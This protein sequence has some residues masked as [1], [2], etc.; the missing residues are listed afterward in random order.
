MSEYFAEYI[1][2]DIRD[3]AARDGTTGP[4]LRSEM[5]SLALYNG[6]VADWL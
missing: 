6:G 1:H 4:L 2:K 3:L 5:H